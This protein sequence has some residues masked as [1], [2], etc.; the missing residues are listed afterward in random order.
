MRKALEFRFTLSNPIEGSIEIDEPIGWNGSKFTLKRDDRF[1]SILFEYSSQLKFYRANSKY[2]GGGEFILYIEDKYGTDGEVNLLV[3][4]SDHN[5]PWTTVFEGRL[6]LE[7][8]IETERYVECIAEQGDFFTIFNQ[9]TDLQVSFKDNYSVDGV[10]LQVYEPYTL[11]MHSKVLVKRT[12]AEVKQDLAFPPTQTHEVSINFGAPGFPDPNKTGIGDQPDTEFV[13]RTAYI[14]FD[15]SGVTVEELADYWNVG[16]AS[17]PSV[18]SEIYTVKEAGLHSFDISLLTDILASGYRTSGSSTY[19]TCNDTD[20][21][22]LELIKTKFVLKIVDAEDVEKYIEEVGESE[23]NVCGVDNATVEANASFT[24]IIDL[25]L[26]VGDKVYLYAEVTLEATYARQL[27]DANIGLAVGHQLKEGSFIKIKGK[28]FTESSTAPAMRIHDVLQNLCNKLT[29]RD[30][31]FYSEFFGYPGA[32]YHSYISKG[33]GADYVLQCGFNIRNFPWEDRPLQPVFNTIYDSLDSIFGL[34]LSVEV[35]DGLPKIRIEQLSYAYTKEVVLNLDHVSGIK[36]TIAKDKFFNQLVVGYEEWKPEEINGL[37]EFATKHTYS[38]DL[39]TTGSTLTLLSKVIASGSLIEVTRRNQ[40]NQ[41]LTTDTKYDDSLFIVALN[42]SDPTIAEK[43]ENFD[44]VNNLLS[45]E[46]AYNLRLWPAF[47]LLRN[48]SRIN[49]GLLKKLGSFYKFQAGEGNY[50]I[51]MEMDESQTDCPGSYNADML[52]GGTDIQWAYADLPEVEPLWVPVIYEFKYPL[53]V[54]QLLTL[55][56]NKNKSVFITGD[57]FE[58]G[59]GATAFVLEVESEP[60]TGLAS[61]TCLAASMLPFNYVPEDA[62]NLLLQDGN[63]LLLEDG[64]LMLI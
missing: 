50:V 11:N 14:Q 63:N 38:T 3:E 57:L 18:P 56:L 48:G 49:G 54:D 46:T 5:G 37:D 20:N 47:T 23:E 42:Q 7:D 24:P 12:E 30:D 32:P 45:P 21:G 26:E 52:I 35:I 16:G 33:C 34:S 28:T 62:D 8:L 4:I 59:Y 27:T 64:S 15:L 41:T 2:N 44:N 19:V 25:E 53:S 31:S 36:R 1:N 43:N 10:A 13:S 40:Y 58:E 17:L 39:R 60:N 22:Y 61:W 9:R 29:N 55:K 6:N 51:E